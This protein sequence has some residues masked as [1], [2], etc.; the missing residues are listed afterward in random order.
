MIAKTLVPGWMQV[1]L[2]LAK[3]GRRSVESHSRLKQLGALLTASNPTFTMPATSH[4]E[5]NDGM[6]V[7]RAFLNL[8][9]DGNKSQSTQ[10]RRCR[11][12]GQE[13]RLVSSLR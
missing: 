12:Q 9:Q 8:V 5:L 4:S 10:G 6:Q 1:L 3:Q 13:V 11:A 7:H 2:K